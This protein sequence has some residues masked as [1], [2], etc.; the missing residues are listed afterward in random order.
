MHCF[1]TFPTTIINVI[2]ITAAQSSM[3]AMTI[4][5]KPLLLDDIYEVKNLEEPTCASQWW[6][7]KLFILL[8]TVHACPSLL[9]T[10][11]AITEHLSF[12]SLTT[13]THIYSFNKH[14]QISLILHTQYHENPRNVHFLCKC[15]ARHATP[16]VDPSDQLIGASDASVRYYFADCLWL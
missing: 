6:S 16:H 13:R 12:L 7:F 5:V 10:R 3:I 15:N 11:I 9:Q 8:L 1:T 4:E 2:T 14:Y